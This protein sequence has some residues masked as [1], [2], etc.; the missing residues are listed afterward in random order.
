MLHSS[1]T[2]DNAEPSPPLPAKSPTLSHRTIARST[3][4]ANIR[5]GA[6]A[7]SGE[8]LPRRQQQPRLH[9]G[10]AQ[11][12]GLAPPPLGASAIRIFRGSVN[13][14]HQLL[15]T[16]RAAAEPAPQKCGSAGTLSPSPAAAQAPLRLCD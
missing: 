6:T 8:A 1:R 5:C 4:A 13:R 12:L 11:Q 15:S 9:G 14:T 3:V 2:V 16:A 10:H 7:G